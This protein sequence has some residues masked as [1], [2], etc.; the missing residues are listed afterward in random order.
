MG[1]TSHL[2]A[3]QPDPP[4]TLTRNFPHTTTRKRQVI[5]PSHTFKVSQPA[6]PH[7]TSSP[8]RKQS[9]E[10]GTSRSWSNPPSLPLTPRPATTSPP[11]LPN[12]APT[13]IIDNPHPQSTFSRHTASTHHV[14]CPAPRSR[15]YWPTSPPN[16]CLISTGWDKRHPPQSNYVS[17]CMHREGVQASNPHT[18]CPLLKS[19]SRDSTPPR[20]QVHEPA[21]ILS[22]AVS[23]PIS[24]ECKCDETYPYPVLLLVP[25]H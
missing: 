2:T 21:L 20:A 4:H 18:W 6:S 14:R 23:E 17:I 22:L 3:T 25:L 10:R 1:I 8:K 19:S 12:R 7:R 16:H 15:T 5:L 24:V 11:I 9:T 13:P